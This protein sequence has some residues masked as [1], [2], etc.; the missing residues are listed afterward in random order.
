MSIGKRK[1]SVDDDSDKNAEDDELM[2]VLFQRAF[3]AK[4][5]PLDR[6]DIA[7]QPYLGED[8]GIYDGTSDTSDW[9]GVSDDED[10]HGDQYAEDAI[11]TI[12]HT[13][14]LG[15][16]HDLERSERKAFMVCI[17]YVLHLRHD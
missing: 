10:E 16:D 7:P 1:R 17:L 14:T 15:T 13:S 8:D 4:F 3:E 2:R 5:K 9:S 6:S 11:E 12:V